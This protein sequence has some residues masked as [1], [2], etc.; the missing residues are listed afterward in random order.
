MYYAVRGIA[1]VVM[2]GLFAGPVGLLWQLPTGLAIVWLILN[3]EAQWRD[4]PTPV[5]KLA[6]IIGGGGTLVF[7][8]LGLVPNIV[9]LAIAMTIVWFGTCQAL[10][11]LMNLDLESG[12]RLATRLLLTI[13]G[14]WILIGAVRLIIENRLWDMSSW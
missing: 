13:W 9:T 8:V 5:L 12:Q 4:G 1:I 6:A 3:T 7:T 2:A 11:R 10:D 14:A